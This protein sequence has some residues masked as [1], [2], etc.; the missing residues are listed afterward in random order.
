MLIDS[1]GILF[2]CLSPLRSTFIEDTSKKMTLDFQSHWPNL[3]PI[4]YA[5][6]PH[7]YTVCIRYGF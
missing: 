4:L 2:I 1:R 5:F 6:C 3:N 7:P